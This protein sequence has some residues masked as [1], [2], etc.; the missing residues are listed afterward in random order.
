MV[1]KNVSGHFHR[2]RLIAVMGPSGCGKTSFMNRLNGRATSYGVPGGHLIVNG[3]ERESLKGLGS[4]VGFVLQDDIMHEDL[5]VRQVL[6]YQT[7]L[8]L[9]TTT[10]EETRI[11]IVDDVMIMLDINHLQHSV[12]GSALSRGIS[13]GQKKRVNI[14]MEL[15]AYPTVLF[16]DEPTSGLIRRPPSRS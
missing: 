8:R 16:L 4:K 15:V 5:T 13:G 7:A 6:T 1:L 2:Q 11:N 3:V 14:A 9:P 12:V 10:D